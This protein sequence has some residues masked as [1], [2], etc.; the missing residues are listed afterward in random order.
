MK[1]DIE[2]EHQ[3]ASNEQRLVRSV[4]GYVKPMHLQDQF[5]V[6]EV[7]STSTTYDRL[8]QGMFKLSPRW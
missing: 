4:E 2:G 5:A 7:R 6:T 1:R 3:R 8:L